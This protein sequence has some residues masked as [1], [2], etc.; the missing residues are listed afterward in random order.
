MKTKVKTA[1]MID[2]AKN[3]VI[4]AYQAVANTAEHEKSSINI[5][6]IE[7]WIGGTEAAFLGS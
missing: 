7:T 3:G 5:C 1:R 4:L 6:R 2:M